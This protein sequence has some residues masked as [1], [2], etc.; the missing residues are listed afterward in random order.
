MASIARFLPAA[1]ALLAAPAQARAPVEPEILV[2]ASPARPFAGTPVPDPVLAG[3][4]GGVQLPNGLTVSI[5]IDI[6]TRVNG[7]LVLHTIYAS[8][9]PIVGVRVF[10]DGT[11]P[12]RTAP[13]TVTVVTPGSSGSPTVEVTRTPA[14]VTIIPGLTASPQTVNLVSGPASTW[15]MATGQAEVPVVANGPAVNAG[16]GAF[17]LATN[18]NGAIVTL[19]APM[20]QIQ[21]LVGQ[22]T[23]ITVANTANDQLID[24]VSSV[25]VDLQGASVPLLSS[26][27]AADSLALEIARGR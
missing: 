23:G 3:M 4:R 19:D 18:D 2:I 14:G 5:G 8:D 10:T 16:P 1:L 17:S 22:A 25:N 15:V 24:T 20:L 7:L 9:G 12:V 11:D 6:Q 26:L 27:L 21:H 13:D